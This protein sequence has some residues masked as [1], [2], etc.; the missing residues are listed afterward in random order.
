MFWER[1]LQRNIFHSVLK[2]I[3]IVCI[4]TCHSLPWNLIQIYSQNSEQ[5]N[6]QQNPLIS[7]NGG[8]AF[9]P[10]GMVRQNE[11]IIVS[12][13][14]SAATHTHKIIGNKNTH[15]TLWVDQAADEDF[16]SLVLL[17]VLLARHIQ[18]GHGK[19][20]IE[21]F[22]LLSSI[23]LE[24]LC[25]LM[26]SSWRLKLL[27]LESNK[28]EKWG[29]RYLIL[30]KILFLNLLRTARNLVESVI[31]FTMSRSNQTITKL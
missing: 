16:E 26:V 13:M 29:F 20:Y 9:S 24:S 25:D 10:D 11:T 22:G 7:K 4:K 30:R 28:L 19:L 8:H 31:L 14:R 3:S 27:H 2:W 6:V 15:R 12:E 18:S 21:S 17:A 5:W 23:P 1:F